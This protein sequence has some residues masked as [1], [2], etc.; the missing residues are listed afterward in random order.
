MTTR[1]NPSSITHIKRLRVEYWYTRLR[2]T[3]G[4]SDKQ[5]NQLLNPDVD[6]EDAKES[7][8]FE[9]LRKQRTDPSRG[10]LRKDGIDIVEVMDHHFPGSRLWFE[11]S[12]WNAVS[13]PAPTAMAA[14]DAIARECEA[15]ALRRSGHDEFL[16]LAARWTDLSETAAYA[17]ITRKSLW[18]LSRIERLG[19]L[20]LLYREA[21]LAV[22]YL[23]MRELS[24]QI[25]EEADLMFCEALGLGRGAIVYN[26]ILSAILRA[27][28]A[29]QQVTKA[30][31]GFGSRACELPLLRDA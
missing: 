4:L 21:E 13:C 14:E 2:Q 19:V 17:R 7:K 15:L 6:P 10:R 12:L 30:S 27:P 5:L 8:T 20:V 31:F 22:E 24:V 23:I 11:S 9:R 1:R 29:W 26:E 18:G 28:R 16:A 3:S 25:D